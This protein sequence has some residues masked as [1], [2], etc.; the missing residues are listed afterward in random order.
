MISQLKLY[1]IAAVLIALVG[2]SVLWRMEVSSHDLT[3]EKL[4]Q[5]TLQKEEI[6]K[7]RSF[8]QEELRSVNRANEKL[9]IK[10]HAV[11]KKQS[12]KVETLNKEFSENEMLKKCGDVKLSSD[13]G[14]LFL[15]DTN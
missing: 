11:N 15:D 13:Y 4:S 1:A 3:S 12:T 7:Q 10:D 8:L 5:V 2:L 6:E 9:A 14:R